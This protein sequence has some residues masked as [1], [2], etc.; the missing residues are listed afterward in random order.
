MVSV[1]QLCFG[2]HTSAQ[3]TYWETMMRVYE[4][5]HS[6]YCGIGL[7]ARSLH[8]CVLDHASKV[9]LDKNLAS[10]PET[11]LRALE[12]FCDGLVI[13]VECM[14]AWYCVRLPTELVSVACCLTAARLIDT[15]TAAWLKHPG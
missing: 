4:G 6:F 2:Y 14:F 8:V 15:D 7:H 11:L 3:S 13:G 10:R 1:Q 5:Q 9:V 12:P